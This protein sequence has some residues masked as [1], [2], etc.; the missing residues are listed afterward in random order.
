VAKDMHRT[1]SCQSNAGKPELI[2]K[3]QLKKDENECSQTL[4][5]G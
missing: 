4:I 1:G 2:R 5:L 3:V